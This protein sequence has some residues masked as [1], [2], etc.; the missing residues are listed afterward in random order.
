MR[1]RL[2]SL[3]AALLISQSVLHAA[4]S[5]ESSVITLRADDV[6]TIVAGKGHRT[7]RL[8]GNSVVAGFAS[9][10]NSIEWIVNAP[11]AEDYAISLIFSSPKQQ[12]LEV[13]CGASVVTAPSLIKTSKDRPFYWRQELPGVLHLEKGENQITFRLPDAQPGKDGQSNKPSISKDPDEFALYSIE[14]GTPSAHK[15]QLERAKE[16][17]GDTSWMIA[18]KYGIFVHWSALS[19]PFRG[20][21]P[22]ARWFQESVAMFDVKTSADAVERAGAAWVTFTATHKGFYWPGPNAALDTILPGRT[23]KRDLLGEIMDEL[24]RRG[25]RTLLYLHTSYNCY[26]SEFRK[27]AG[28]DD[29]D[30]KRFSDNTAAILRDCSLRYGKKLSGFDYIDGALMWGYPLDPSW[31]SWSRAIKAG[32]PAAVVGFSSN[33]GPTVSPFSELSVTDSG[34][35][36]TWPDPMLIGPGRQLGDVTPASWCHMDTWYAGKPMNGQFPGKPRYSA[37]EYVDY[38]QRMAEAKVPVT[39]NLVMTADVTA[40]HP[41]FNPKCMAVMVAVRKAIRGK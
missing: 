25:I 22:R 30:P 7:G 37:A 11:K 33:R 14:L 36:L 32:N 2:A 34:G 39:I 35:S 40:E 17:R 19:Y 27:A 24:G 16:I 41:I 12:T 31:E 29:A 5:A 23:A 9:P 20:D 21:E 4:E 38:F 28:A 1:T 10:A 8:I 6:T 13:R 18:G 3:A 26:E 15:A